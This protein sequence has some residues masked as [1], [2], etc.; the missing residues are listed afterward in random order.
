MHTVIDDKLFLNGVYNLHKY[1]FT[2]AKA[3]ELLWLIIDQ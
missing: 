3:A 1:A 2:D